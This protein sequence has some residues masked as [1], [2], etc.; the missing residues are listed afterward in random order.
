MA[1]VN[2]YTISTLILLG[3]V[4]PGPSNA[5]LSC[6]TARQLCSEDSVCSQILEILPKVCGL[7]LVSCSTVTVTK[8]QAALRTLQGF[9]YFSP[10]CLC[11]EPHRDPEC[12]Q[13]REYLFDHPCG[14]V[15]TKE[16][17]PY[18]IDALPTCNQ[19]LSVCQKDRDCK[20]IY[21]NFQQ[22]CKVQNGQCQMGAA[23][24]R[25]QSAWSQLRLSPMF[26]CICPGNSGK[27]KCDRVF[28]AVNGNP[29]ID[30]RFFDL[31]STLYSDKRQT[32][33]RFWHF[34][35]NTTRLYTN[36]PGQKPYDGNIFGNTGRGKG[37]GKQGGKT[38]KPPRPTPRTAEVTP[39]IGV[40]FRTDSQFS[41]EQS[42]ATQVY[43]K[44]TYPGP[45]KDN[46]G[47]NGQVGLKSTCHLALNE[48]ER[49]NSCSR[50]LDQVKK[51]CDP[52]TCDRNKCMRAIRDFYANIPERHS[53][54]IAFCLCKQPFD[55]V[56]SS[57]LRGRYLLV[58]DASSNTPSP[59]EQCLRAQ[60]LLHPVCAQQPE[61]GGAFD[62]GGPGKQAAC[63]DIAHACS[64][65]SECN[66]RLERYNQVCSVDTK[67]ISCAGAPQACRKGMI[68]I[69]GTELRTNCGCEGTAAD[70]RELYDCIGWHRILWQNPCVVEAQKDYHRIRGNLLPSSNDN[71][72]SGVGGMGITVPYTVPPSRT[73]P[74]PPPQ[75]VTRRP[76]P[77]TRRPPPTRPTRRPRP[78]PNPDRWGTTQNNWELGTFPP[79]PMM[80]TIAPKYP[81]NPWDVNNRGNRQ[82]GNNNGNNI[83]FPVRTT[84]LTPVSTTTT[85]TTTTLP[86]KFCHLERPG[87]PVKYIR[88]GYKKRLY[89]HDD[90]ECSELC[91]CNLGEVLSCKVLE[92]I[93]RDACNTGV[94]FYSHAS[95]FYQAYRGQCLCYS[96]SFVCSKPPKDVELSLDRGVYLYLGYSQKDESLLKK[97][98]S[99]G[100]LEAIGAIQGLVSYHNVNSN[101]SECRILL[102]KHSKEN[103]VLQAVMDEFEENREKGNLTAE[104][105][106]REKDECYDAL[107]SISRKINRND[108]DMRSHVI[109]SMIKVA[110]AEADVPDPPP[111]G[112]PPGFEPRTSL[113]VFNVL[114]VTMLSTWWYSAV[115]RTGRTL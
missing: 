56:V 86:P 91:E 55:F 50:Y 88:E 105:L 108:A 82:R 100:A 54:D 60:S 76:P 45:R 107:K 7:E 62:V 8:C 1:Q 31:S 29:C 112:S 102:K 99:Q 84:T 39:T 2:F 38:L 26:G 18:P 47:G 36:R 104:L 23:W 53:L 40:N 97:V 12:N 27:E 42:V 65:N 70:F 106:N 75:V 114:L 51:M 49:D 87:Q 24:Q 61:Q 95:P 13:I 3:F 74:P 77:P 25:C 64:G 20:K 80:P 21:E 37:G 14:I 72:G 10:T 78:K 52:I 94:A 101:K 44:A 35:Y 5:L 19:A 67:T 81:S 48:C 96:G 83:I 17:D 113:L 93:E 34:W 57:V 103:I 115:T 4:T 43:D 69:L 58:P 89:K 32:A 9:P 79:T 85:T 111:S 98:T 15:N 63:H 11:Q 41:V 92:C 28:K 59:D 46:A 16:S 71:S 68:D 90:P 22:A 33:A 110:A 73:R 6:I 109:L 30:A 66:N